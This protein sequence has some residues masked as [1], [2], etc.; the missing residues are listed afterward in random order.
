M[1][2]L[3][4]MGSARERERER[5]GSSMGWERERVRERERESQRRERERAREVLTCQERLGYRD[6]DT[7]VSRQKGL[8]G[9]AFALARPLVPS[10]SYFY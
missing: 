8:L 1:E 4:A 5:E 2:S 3:T 9:P 6:A 10:N 7:W